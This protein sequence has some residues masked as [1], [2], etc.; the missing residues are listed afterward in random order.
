M[1]LF[2]CLL[3]SARLST[4]LIFSTTVLDIDVYLKIDSL[5]SFVEVRINAI[6]YQFELNERENDAHFNQIQESKIENYSTSPNLYYFLTYHQFNVKY[7][8]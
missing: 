1:F 8:Q 4:D 3:L 7:Q 6:T 5:H 2:S